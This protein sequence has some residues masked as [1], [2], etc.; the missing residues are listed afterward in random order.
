MVRVKKCKA[1]GLRQRV[2]LR[3]LC[4]HCALRID[5]ADAQAS[6]INGI[7]EDMRALGI[8]TNKYYY[9]YG[10]VLDKEEDD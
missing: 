3:Q 7:R 1:C 2:D 4:T 5:N 6:D 10:Q 9:K 8:P